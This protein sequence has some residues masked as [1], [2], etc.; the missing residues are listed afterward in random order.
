MEAA[1]MVSRRRAQAVAMGPQGGRQSAKATAAPPSLSSRTIATASPAD[2]LEMK[3]T[4]TDG[5]MQFA[6]RH[7]TG[8][9][10]LSGW[11][12]RNCRSATE[13]ADDQSAQ[14]AAGRAWTGEILALPNRRNTYTVP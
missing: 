8:L 4:H 6:R 2:T 7:R 1:W 12:G 11:S 9:G 14:Q 13:V 10:L 5:S 3:K